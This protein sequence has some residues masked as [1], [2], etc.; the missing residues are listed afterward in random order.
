MFF[1]PFNGESYG[2]WSNDQLVEAASNL[3]KHQVSPRGIS[4][5]APWLGNVSFYVETL[6][7]QEGHYR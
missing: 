4:L 2:N 6:N 7:K 5:E 3:Q 1:G